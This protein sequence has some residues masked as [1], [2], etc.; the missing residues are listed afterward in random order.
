MT[1]VKAERLLGSSH[2][3]IMARVILRNCSDMKQK[4]LLFDL[5]WVRCDL[6]GG[7]SPRQIAAFDNKYSSIPKKFTLVKCSSCGLIYLNPRPTA[8][9]MAAFYSEH[10][11]GTRPHINI[12]VEKLWRSFSRMMTGFNPWLHGFRKGTLLDVGCGD[13][14]YLDGLREMGWK[15]LYGLDPSSIATDLT[16]ARGFEV[17]QGDLLTNNY[18]DSFFDYVIMKQSLEHI[19]SPSRALMNVRRILKD[20]GTLIVEVPNVSSVERRL[21]QSHWASWHLPAH[22][23]HFS[24]NT[25]RNLLGRC[26]FSVK[27]VGHS[28]SPGMLIQSLNSLFG[29]RLPVNDI[30][31]QLF[32]VLAPFA[33][34]CALGQTSGTIIVEAI[35]SSWSSSRSKRIDNLTRKG[36]VEPVS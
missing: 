13:G 31:M 25:L 17:S 16:S 11:Y 30:N 26:G 22:L 19:R 9:S 15:E 6:C 35:K 14:Y 5:E 7:D 12:G 29:K 28:P 32:L 3:T 21:F 8:D 33:A 10:Y 24:P 20:T 36:D 23:Y 34:V 18:P 1:C 27:K 4:R 2:T